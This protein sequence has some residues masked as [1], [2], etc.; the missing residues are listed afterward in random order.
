MTGANGYEDYT[1]SD[2]F[3]GRNKFEGLG[4]QQ[5]MMRDGGFKVRT[6]LLSSKVAKTDDWLLAANFS[7]SI[8]PG[9]NPLNLLPIKI[10][11]KIFVDIGTYAEAWK[12]DDGQ[13]RF[14]YDAGFQLSLFKDVLNIYFPVL[15]SKVYHDYY[16][17]T[18]PDKKYGKTISF[19]ID[20]QKISFRKLFPQIPF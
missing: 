5:I 7:S 2:Y 9:I 13:G 14:L 8:P 20:I 17:S 10:P 19:S 4:S 3:I 12:T 16:K 1:Y 15:Y 11:L 18:M 6:D